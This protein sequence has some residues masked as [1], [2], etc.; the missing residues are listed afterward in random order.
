[1]IHDL[2]VLMPICVLSSSFKNGFISKHLY[3]EQDDLDRTGLIRAFLA[4][5]Q[6]APPASKFVPDKFVE[7]AIFV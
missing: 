6:R 7:P 5:T 2:V 3:T 1:M 4:L